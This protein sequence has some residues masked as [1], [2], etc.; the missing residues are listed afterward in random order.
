MIHTAMRYI[1][2]F[3]SRRKLSVTFSSY[4]LLLSFIHSFFLM[5]GQLWYLFWRYCYHHSTKGSPEWNDLH[6]SDLP[7]HF[8]SAI[9]PFEKKST[10]SKLIK[11]RKNFRKPSPDLQGA[12]CLCYL[13][14][15]YTMHSFNWPKFWFF[16]TYPY[17]SDLIQTLFLFL[18]SWKI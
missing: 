7:F 1:L 17:S 8:L 6:K 3:F 4:F 15:W 5:Q 14:K 16:W 2:Q 9:S 13:V 10:H 12:F 18:V 11:F